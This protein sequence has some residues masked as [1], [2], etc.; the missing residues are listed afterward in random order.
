MDSGKADIAKAK[1]FVTTPA[2]CDYNWTVRGSPDPALAEEIKQTFLT[3]DP[4]KPANREI[5]DLQAA[6]CFVETSPN[7][8]K[9]I[10]ESI[11]ATGLLK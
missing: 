8:Y 6:S 7:N 2:Y 5:L 1:V 11:H 9:G 4:A 3:L 10:E